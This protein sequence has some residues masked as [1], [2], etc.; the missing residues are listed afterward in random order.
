MIH[1]MW[2]VAMKLGLGL[3]VERVGTK[4]NIADLPPRE[5]YD[6]SEKLGA[7]WVPPKL[8]EAFYHP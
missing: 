8:S 1:S 7:S 4:D 5:S 2:M 6:L 3:W